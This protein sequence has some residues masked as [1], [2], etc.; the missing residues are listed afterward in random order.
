M[1]TEPPPAALKY[2]PEAA[3]DIFTERL[4]IMREGNNIPDNQPTPLPIRMECI[5]AAEREIE[6]MREKK[7]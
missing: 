5:K 3:Q 6:M 2:W 1:T 7:T 4:A